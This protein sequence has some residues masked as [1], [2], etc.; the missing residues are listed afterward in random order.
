MTVKAAALA[1]RIVSPW[2]VFPDFFAPPDTEKEEAAAIAR[3]DEVVHDYSDL[4]WAMPS[5]TGEDPEETL[6]LLQEM[7]ANLNLS[8]TDDDWQP[9]AAP[10]IADVLAIDEAEREWL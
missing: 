1:G 3:G 2:R 4:D 8:V 7:G 5:E 9:E 10:Q 6:A